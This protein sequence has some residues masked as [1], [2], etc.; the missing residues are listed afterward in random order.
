MNEQTNLEKQLVH[1][2]INSMLLVSDELYENVGMSDNP[3]DWVFSNSS[4]NCIDPDRGGHP[5]KLYKFFTEREESTKSNALITGTLLHKFMENRESF[6]I[7]EVEKPGDKLAIAADKLIEIALGDVEITDEIIVSAIRAADWNSK[8]GDEAVLKNAKPQIMPY[9]NEVLKNTGKYILSKTVGES[10]SNAIESIQNNSTIQSL[11]FSHNEN[12]LVF[13][14]LEL[15]G[16]YN[17]LKIKGKL[18]RVHID[19]AAKTIKIFDYKTSSG[20]L[21]RF[22]YHF[23][24]YKYY[25]QMAFYRYLLQDLFPDY[26]ITVYIVGVETNGLFNS[27][28]MEISSPWLEAGDLEMHWLFER[29]NYHIDNDV[30]TRTMEEDLDAGVLTLPFIEFKPSPVFLAKNQITQSIKTYE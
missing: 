16:I 27:N 18:D 3:N 28:I 8:W 2:I 25:R 21:A 10:L 1:D 12:T 20:D 19:C 4:L 13:K 15:Y 30:F 17:L 9:V 14:E 29:V 6:G 11:V 22:A 7:S 23:K 26:S 24:S 5:K